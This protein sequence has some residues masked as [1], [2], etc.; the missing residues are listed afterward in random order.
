MRGIGDQRHRLQNVVVD[1]AYVDDRPVGLDATAHAE[2]AQ[3][4]IVERPGCGRISHAQIE[5]IDQSIAHDRRVL[6]AVVA[7]HQRAPTKRPDGAIANTVSLRARAV[8]A[9]R[10]ESR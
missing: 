8:A 2:R 5:M 4:W 3:Q 6:Y 7:V 10:R 1:D 9:R